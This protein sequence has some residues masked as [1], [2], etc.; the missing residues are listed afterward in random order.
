MNQK[1][2]EILIIPFM[3][4]FLFFLPSHSVFEGTKMKN[5][6]HCLFVLFFAIAP[7]IEYINI[8][9]DNFHLIWERNVLQIYEVIFCKK[10]KIIAYPLI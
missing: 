2:M 7:H 4:Y 1:V 9:V 8:W 3:L 6:L 10:K 5:Q